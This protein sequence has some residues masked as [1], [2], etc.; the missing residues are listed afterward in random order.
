MKACQLD[1]MFA[2]TAVE[3][4]I[5]TQLGVLQQQQTH[6]LQLLQQLT[7]MDGINGSAPA[8]LR[9]MFPIA[10]EEGLAALEKKLS[11]SPDLKNKLVRR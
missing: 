3:L 2:F 1:K 5:L 7:N 8:S 6:I 4:E 11:Q 10:D 9:A